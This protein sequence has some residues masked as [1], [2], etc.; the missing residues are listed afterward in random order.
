MLNIISHQEDANRM[1]PHF[2][3]ARTARSTKVDENNHGGDAGNSHR[4]VGTCNG[5]AAVGNR[6]AA[7]QDVQSAVT[8][9]PSNATPTCASQRNKNTCSHKA[10]AQMLQ[11]HYSCLVS[12]LNQE[13]EQSKC[14]SPGDGVNKMWSSHEMEYYLGTKKNGVQTQT[15]SQMN[16][17]NMV[18]GEGSQ[19]GKTTSCMIP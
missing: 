12:Q 14:P 9:W 16:L 18:P 3:P 4:L 10:C 6:S 8:G 1:R 11:Q 13:W 19:A 7:P 2:T 15:T 5:A 17:E